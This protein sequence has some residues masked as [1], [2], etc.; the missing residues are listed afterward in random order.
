M[1]GGV[2]VARIA[3]ELRHPHVSADE[4]IEAVAA[5][6]GDVV[7]PFDD[8]RFPLLRSI[9]P[10]GDTFFSDYQMAGSFL[11]CGCCAPKRQPPWS[12]V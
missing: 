5:D 3:V 9:D 7:P 2:G 10:H 4:L 6:V 12:S 8:H 11:S 1:A